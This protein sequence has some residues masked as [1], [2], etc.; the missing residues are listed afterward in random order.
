MIGRAI[1]AD[2]GLPGLPLYPEQ[3]ST[4]AERVDHLFL[5]LTAICGGMLLFVVT[6]LIVFSALYY[7]RREGEPTPRI[8]GWTALE[9]FWTVAPVFVFASMFW[10]GVSVYSDTFHPPDN[11]Y[12]VFVVGKQWMWKIQ[13]TGGQREINKLHIP[14]GRPV[15]VTFISEDV[16]HD[17]G[18]PAFRIKTDVV[19]GRYLSTWY[20]P[21][22]VGQ[23]RLFCDQYCG[24]DHA[25]MIGQIIVMRPEDHAAWLRD[26][27]EGSPALEGRKLFLK[28]QCINCHSADAHARAPVLE[29]LYGRRVALRGGGSV[30]ADE[31]YIRQSVLNPATKVV[32]GWEPIMPTFQGQVNEEELIQLIAYIR[33]L[34][35]G[36]T[37][38]R[39]ENF[40]APVGAPTAP[41]PRE[42][43][44]K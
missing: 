33:S 44:P 25:K 5:F 14:V 18:I 22:K 42:V 34:R 20:E 17:F 26:H 3:A 16:I 35:P 27:A 1:F 10:W 21:T 38:T 2:I 32:E 36:G 11:A 19:P 29:G 30:V 24:T 23:Y 12:E 4:H 31:N 6:L 40:P 37:P 41:P 28:L 8:R 9:T 15:K 7:R 39:N 43:R 13:H